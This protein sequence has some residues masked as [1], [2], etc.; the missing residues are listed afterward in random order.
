ME[1]SKNEYKKMNACYERET[2]AE[3]EI[4]VRNVTMEFKREKD[5]AGSVKE[6]L[7][8]TLKGQHS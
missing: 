3:L 6:F 5:E 8:R 7:I 2:K 1:N 4:A